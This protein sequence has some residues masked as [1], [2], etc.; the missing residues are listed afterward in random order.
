MAYQSH[1]HHK[2]VQGTSEA[3]WSLFK[4]YNA[5]L[6]RLK[7]RGWNLEASG[8]LHTTKCLSGGKV[9][10]RALRKL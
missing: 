8:R 6:H 7:A 2:V 9:T 3:E 4:S 5:P 1:I 10:V